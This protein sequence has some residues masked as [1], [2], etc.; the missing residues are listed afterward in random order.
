MV[1]RKDKPLPFGLGH[2]A[3]A[4]RIYPRPIEIPKIEMP[5]IEIP[6]IDIPDLFGSGKKEKGRKRRSK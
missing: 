2:A 3:P 1:C 5:R 4:R 6:E